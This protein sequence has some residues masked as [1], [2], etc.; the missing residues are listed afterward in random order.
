M[1]ATLNETTQRTVL[2]TVGT[3]IFAGACLFG[4]V[5][6]AKAAEAPRAQVVSFSDLDLSNA[7]GRSVLD[8]RIKHAARS[9]CAIGSADLRSRSEEARCI[10][11][12]LDAAAPKVVAAAPAYT[13]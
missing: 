5:A 4:A 13:G 12:A 8:F 10:R 6:P 1:L 9:V 7:K 3:L 11:N 2:G